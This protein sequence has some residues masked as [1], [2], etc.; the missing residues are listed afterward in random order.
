MTRMAALAAALA[1]VAWAF[2]AAAQTCP[3][4]LKFAAGACVQS[5]PGGY[6]DTGT[7]CVDRR[8]GGGGGS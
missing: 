4:G 2:P 8:Q 5:C 3:R 6:E 7:T 1:L